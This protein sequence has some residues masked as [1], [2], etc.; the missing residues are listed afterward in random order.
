MSNTPAERPT[1][2]KSLDKTKN[3][4]VAFRFAAE[5]FAAEGVAAEAVAAEGGAEKR[6]PVRLVARTASPV[7]S[8]YFGTTYHDLAGVQVKDRIPIDYAHDEAEILGFLDNIENTGRELVATGAL[9]PFRGDDRASEIIAKLNQGV[10]YEA[11]INFA[12]PSSIE[13]ISAGAVA[14]VNGETVRG[15]C[16]IFRK[17]TLRGVAICPYGADADTSTA[18]EFSAGETV[19]ATLLSAEPAAPADPATAKPHAAAE[20]PEVPPPAED[21]RT[22]FRRMQEDFGPE[23]AARVFAAGGG[24]EDAKD[25]KLAALQADVARLTDENRAL[26]AAVTAPPLA[27]GTPARA[28]AAPPPAPG[29]PTLAEL[30]VRGVKPIRV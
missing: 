3:P 12:G 23:I 8:W 5:G 26:S 24:Y 28:V 25:A 15:P 14:E 11:S 21:S 6:Y 27:R 20:A 9:T 30:C 7:E 29:K 19:S 16:V 13:E 10:P 1:F 4:A 18:A 17:W 2:A 22:L